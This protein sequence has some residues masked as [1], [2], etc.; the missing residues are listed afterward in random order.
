MQ[1]GTTLKWLDALK[2]ADKKVIYDSSQLRY[3]IGS[4]TY[5]CPF[6]VLL[7]TIDCSKWRQTWDGVSFLWDGSQFSLPSD[8]RQRAKMKTDD[9]DAMIAFEKMHSFVE[10]AEYVRQKYQQI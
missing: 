9:F 6:G 5:M 1:R 2:L 10:A 7:D 3:V 8:F 4:D